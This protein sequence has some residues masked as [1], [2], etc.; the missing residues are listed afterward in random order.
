MCGEDIGRWPWFS[1]GIL[2]NGLLEDVAGRAECVDSSNGLTRD[3][4]F[5]FVKGALL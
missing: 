2:I 3:D 5:I 1:P 4:E